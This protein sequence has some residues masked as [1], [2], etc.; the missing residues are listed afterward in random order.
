L[1]A[2][3]SPTDND[4]A[5]DPVRWDFHL[6]LSLEARIR[7]LPKP[8]SEEVNKMLAAKE[9]SADIMR[10]PPRPPKQKPE[11]PEDVDFAAWLRGEVS[12][13]PWLLSNAAAKYYGSK[14]LTAPLVPD[15]MVALVRDK[16]VVFEHELSRY[17]AWV[18]RI[19][20]EALKTGKSHHHAAHSN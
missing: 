18:L 12:Y 1:R 2:T 16:K 4:W 20:D 9:S 7:G 13:Q 6:Q 17:F 8:T 11:G 15:L 14:Y 10:N 19:Y 3:V 5:S